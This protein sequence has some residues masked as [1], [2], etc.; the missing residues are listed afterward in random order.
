MIS[1]IFNYPVFV[2][3]T[4]FWWFGNRIRKLRQVPDYILYTLEGD[5]SQIPQVGGNP[6]LKMFRPPKISLMELNEQICRIAED[7]R[8][9][10]VVFLLRPLDMP[11][12]KVDELRRLFQKLREAGKTV[13]TWA[14]TYDTNM[15]YLASAADKITL[16]PGGTLAPMGLYSQYIYLADALDLVGIKADFL[17][18]APYKSASDMFS[19]SGMSAEVR[20]MGNWLADST[21]AEILS[22]VSQG[23]KIDHDTAAS[24]LDQT[25]CTDLQAVEIGAV[26][27]LLEEDDLP[28]F[29]GSAEEHARLLPWDDAQKRVLKR[30]LKEPGRFIA[31]LRIEGMIVDGHSST[32]PVDLPIPIPIVFEE[33]SGDVSIVNTIR[34]VISDERV[35]GVVLYVNSRGGSPTASETIRHALFKLAMKKPLVVVMGPVA[36]S[37]GY[38]VSTPGKILIAQPNTLTGSIGVI[39]GKFADQ[40]LLKKLFINI[41]T[42]K[43]GENVDIYSSEAPFNEAEK[44]QVGHYLKRTYDMFLERVSESRQ[45]SLDEVDAIG[46]GRVWTGKQALENGLVDELGGLDLG[47][48]KIREMTGLSER[49]HVQIYEP[50]KGYIPPVARGAWA[51]RY[52]FENIRYFNGKVT[53]ICPWLNVG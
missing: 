36:A 33:R 6:L 53:C 44:G 12:A 28:I 15:Y 34:Q 48:D 30:R 2:I 32:P 41:E 26:D 9:K 19:R 18:T 45:F 35:Q 14:Y 10:G 1:H 7:T 31:L 43:R 51:L 46:G 40:G 24:L 25:P 5:Y 39:L 50:K 16:L 47:L 21:Y 8:V 42:I 3:Q 37:G 17:Q 20:E 52:G 4:F 27:A 13:M 49:T 38:W 29:L 22:K 23:R 11:L